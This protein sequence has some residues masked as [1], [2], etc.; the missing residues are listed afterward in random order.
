MKRHRQ[1]LLVAALGIAALV[2]AGDRL[3][4]KSVFTGPLDRQ[5]Q[6]KQRLEKMLQARQAEL[7]QA[8]AAVKQLELWQRRSLPSDRQVARS[9]YQAWLLDL[10]GR[11]GLAN[12]SVD[13]GEPR[14]RGGYYQISF[15]VQGRGSLEQLTEFLHEFYSA[16][17]LHQIQSLV[18]APAGRND[19]LDLSFT[20]EALA[21]AGADRKDRLTSE[22]S[23]RLACASLED[24]EV[25][26][27]RN[28]FG[29][30]GPVDP[31]DHTF[32]TGINYVNGEPEAWFTLRMADDPD[33]ALLKL[34][35]GSSL[36]IGQ[37]SGTV[38]RIGEDDVVLEADGERWLLGIGESL[39]QAYALPPEY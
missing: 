30:S 26:A 11:V 18:I 21:L 20:I 10:V 29:T 31:T 3:G 9:L 16:G 12:H 14:N 8:R 37:F 17:H 36:Q 32:L 35:M 6:S 33:Q 15:T 13:A 28:L 25:I 19:M 5:Y 7:S 34:H 39:A 24:Y 2:V 23:T 27:Q 1:K 38:V 4:W 22:K